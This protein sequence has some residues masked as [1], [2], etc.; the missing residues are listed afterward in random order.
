VSPP[1]GAASVLGM[2]PRTLYERTNTTATTMADLDLLLAEADR[3]DPYLATPQR[4]D[5]AD[6]TAEIDDQI[7]AGLVTP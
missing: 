5:V 6:E 1:A 4:A 3:E 7:L 2:D